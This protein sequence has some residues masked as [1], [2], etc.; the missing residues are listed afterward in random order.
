M[1]DG[2]E[3]ATMGIL[4]AG[5]AGLG[6]SLE[7]VLFGSRAAAPPEVLF[8]VA[9]IEPDERLPARASELL[10]ALFPGSVCGYRVVHPGES[11]VT[12]VLGPADAAAAWELSD[13]LRAGGSGRGVPAEAVDHGTLT[14]VAAPI[15]T[16]GVIGLHRPG[17]RLTAHECWVVQTV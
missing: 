11:A 10:L 7:D 1:K 5:A 2:G 3:R 15:G 13:A 16:H 12:R 6:R 9:V 17:G 14:T 4:G 8:G